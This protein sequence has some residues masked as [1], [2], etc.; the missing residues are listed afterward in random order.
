MP[1]NAE[2]GK[3]FQALDERYLLPLFSNA[4]A[5]RTFHARKARRASGMG[6]PGGRFAPPPESDDEDGDHPEPPGPEGLED[7]VSPTDLC[8]PPPRRT[9]QSANTHHCGAQFEE[10]C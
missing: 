2:E 9:L 3:W 8:V 7:V 5:S 6:T 1:T 4:T 10:T